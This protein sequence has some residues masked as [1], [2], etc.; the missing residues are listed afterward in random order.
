[1]TVK[2]WSPW[3]D[4]PYGKLKGDKSEAYFGVTLSEAQIYKTEDAYYI[5]GNATNYINV[6]KQYKPSDPM[7]FGLVALPIYGKPYE[8]RA[9]N[10]KG[11]YESSEY[12]PSK[13]E[14]VLYEK[15]ALKE[16]EVVG[17]NTFWSVEFMHMP[18]GMLGAA[19][20]AEIKQ[21]VENNVIFEPVTSSGV[22]AKYTPP[23][24]YSNNRSYSKSYG[25]SPEQKLE[26]IR[27]QLAGDIKDESFNSE[28]SLYQ[29]IEQM[30]VENPLEQETTVLYFE[31]LRGC[32]G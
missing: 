15:L 5:A 4:D 20:D 28:T 16:S 1:M 7:P 18:N 22:L 32:I 6:L 9:K 14:K 31:M 30:L 13:F 24:N 27:K 29:L 3:K 25:V 23:K 19:S 2:Y 26:F 21:M 8:I 11:D 12:Q 17:E 10:D